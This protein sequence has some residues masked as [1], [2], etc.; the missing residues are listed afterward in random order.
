MGNKEANK[1]EDASGLLRRAADGDE[2]ALRALFGAHRSRMKRMIELRLSRRLSGRVDNSDV[3]QEAYIEIAR[4]L[5]DYA[6][7][8]KL[9]PFTHRALGQNP[10]SEML[11]PESMVHAFSEGFLPKSRQCVNS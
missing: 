9:P 8:L 10:A 7:E 6:R 11:A 4:N 5:P 1:P 2:G 3:L